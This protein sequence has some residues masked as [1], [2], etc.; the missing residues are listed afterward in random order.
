MGT[1]KLLLR[2][3]ECI[4]EY[5]CQRWIS[6][7]ITIY[8]SSGLHVSSIIGFC[9]TIRRT[10]LCVLSVYGQRYSVTLIHDMCLIT[11]VLATPTT[12]AASLPDETV[13]LQNLVQAHPCSW[14]NTY[15]SLLW[16]RQWSWLFCRV[17]NEGCLVCFFHILR[18]NKAALLERL[19]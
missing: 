4:A 2:P 12:M 11:H 7:W 8:S 17:C 10:L 13:H 5:N 18:N 3:Q 6:L 9:G 14:W 15:S 19:E 1:E 16:G